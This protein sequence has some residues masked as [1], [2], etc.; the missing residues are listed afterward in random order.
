MICSDSHVVII[1]SG[2]ET[3]LLGQNYTHFVAFF[4][5]EPTC[6]FGH[7]GAQKAAVL[8][9]RKSILGPCSSNS[10]RTP[11]SSFPWPLV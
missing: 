8:D 1:L 7:I 5:I 9:K 3:G 11:L 2:I 6:F 4:K 10:L